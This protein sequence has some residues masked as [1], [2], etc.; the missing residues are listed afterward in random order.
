MEHP[1]FIL[2]WPSPPDP[3][4]RTTKPRTLT[5]TPWQA[6]YSICEA[7]PAPTANQSLINYTFAVTDWA[8]LPPSFPTLGFTALIDY[9]APALGGAAYQVEGGL[10][11]MLLAAP[12]LVAQ[13]PTRQFSL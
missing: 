10:C 13:V 11:F 7:A 4:T 3:L 9:P 5:L 1:A 12:R 2:P 6:Y 8:A